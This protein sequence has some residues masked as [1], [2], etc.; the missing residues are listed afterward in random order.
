MALTRVQATGKVVADSVASIALTFSTLPTVGNGLVVLVTGYN[1]TYLTTSCSD[2]RSNTY[3]R[4]TTLSLGPV[5]VAIYSCASVA[6]SV[7]PFTVT[8]AAGTAYYVATAIEVSGVGSGLVLDQTATASAGASTSASTGTTPALTA[9]E[10]LVVSVC[11]LGNTV[12]SLTVDAVSPA[13]TQEAEELNFSLHAVGESDSRIVTSAIGTT[14]SCG[15]TLASS[16]GW[17]GTIAT[18]KA[19]GVAAVETVQPF[20]WGPL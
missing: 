18:F 2:N 6:T 17:A 20:V 5:S 10:E 15:W 3:Q 7:A 19:S 9:A 8:V 1:G 11:S 16:V 4:A 13:W 14:Q 12:A